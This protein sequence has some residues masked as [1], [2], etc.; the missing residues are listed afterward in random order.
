MSDNSGEAK[1]SG[2]RGTVVVVQHATDPLASANRSLA[3]GLPKR[4]NQRV[5]NALVVSLSMV[6]GHE[7]GHRPAKMPFPQ[8]DDAIEAL[9][10]DRPNEPLCVGVAVGCSEWRANDPDSFL[11]EEF[12]HG[13]TPLPV[14][15]TDQDGTADQYTV[16]GIRQVTHG[17][18]DE[19]FVPYRVEPARWTRRDC[20]SITNSV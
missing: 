1:F 14:A 20:S 12:Q 13:T 15:V 5:T 18:N 6:V 16:N 9:F 7:L 8:R 3:T 11:F 2:L 10:L 17:L 4:L 19:C